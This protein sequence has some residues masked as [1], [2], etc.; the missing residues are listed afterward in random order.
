MFSRIASYLKRKPLLVAPVVAVSAAAAIVPILSPAS[1]STAEPRQPA[2][3]DQNQNNSELVDNVV[4]A[5]HGGAGTIRREDL[6]PELEESYRK[7]LTRA[8]RTGYRAIEEGRGSTDAVEA[9]INTMEDSPLFNAGK[10]AVFTTDAQNELDASIMDGETLDAGAVTGVTHIKNPISLADDLMRNSRHV[11]L[12]GQGAEL[13]AQHRGFDLVTQDYFFTQRRWE[14]LRDAKN[15]ESR[16]D[17]GETNTVGAVGLGPNGNLA[18]GTSTGGLTNKPVGRI[19]D[20]PI[21]GAGTYANNETAATSATGTGELF[22]RQAVTHDISALMDYRNLRVDRAANAAIDK[23]EEIGGEDTGGV[24]ALDR[25][26]NLAFVFNTE[27]MYRGYATEDGD[28][29]VKIFADE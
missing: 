7:A 2:P 27:G 26:K 15:G 12:A 11:L 8:V 22:I 19:G 14:S 9:A 21:V 28:I 6:T 5:I 3:R 16:F 10:G 25:D 4:F 29:V 24:I 23:T 18:A 13:Y 1:T 17:F 20:S